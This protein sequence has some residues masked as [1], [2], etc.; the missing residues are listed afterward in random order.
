MTP[1]GSEALSVRTAVVPLLPDELYIETTNRC[2]LKCRT[3][4]QYWG[5]DED[6][7][8]L[9]A[10][11]VERILDLFPNVRRVVLH[12]IG[13]P[14]MNKDL[15]A[16]IRMVKARGAYALFNTNGLLLRGEV[17]RQIAASGLDDLRVS[18]D[19]ASPEIYARVRGANGFGRIVRNVRTFIG[20]APQADEAAPR[21]SLWLTG[22]KANVGELTGLV[23]IAHEIG[24]RQVYL[25]RLVYSE[26]GL[27]SA[28]E[29]LFA[30]AGDADAGEVARAGT[31]ARELGIELRGSGDAAPGS[32]TGRPMQTYRDCRRPWT[33]MYVTAN[34]NVLPCCIAPFTG[35]PYGSLVLGNVFTESPEQI[36]NGARYQAW[37]SA[38]LSDTPPAACAG[39]G[40]AWSL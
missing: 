17:A 23:R 36:W 18:I 9:T 15:P 27:A 11:H 37:R 32:A 22:M 3:C 5:M 1:T 12:G 14:L 28:S 39:C 38:M 19:A 6:A 25:Q 40:V 20:S 16:I 7:A 4:P 29:A 31:L 8:D 10:A 30:D 26:R 24:V 21:V 2:N 35:T 34:G 33:L 13:E